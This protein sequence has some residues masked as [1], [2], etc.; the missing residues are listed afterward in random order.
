MSRPSQIGSGS[1]CLSRPLCVSLSR[2]AWRSVGST[3]SLLD[4]GYLGFA[5]FSAISAATHTTIPV[6]RSP[7]PV[8]ENCQLSI[9][10]NYPPE[11]NTRLDFHMVGVTYKVDSTD[12]SKLIENPIDVLMKAFHGL[13]ALSL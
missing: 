9:S 11:K 8:H 12:F 10:E 3:I 6:L 7:M 5:C 13:N 4:I 2:L 1:R